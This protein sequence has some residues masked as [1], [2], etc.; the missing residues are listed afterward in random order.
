M[1]VPR[2][3]L[4][5]RWDVTIVNDQ[6]D[7]RCDAVSV[8]VQR[9]RVVLVNDDPLPLALLQSDRQP[10]RECHLPSVLSSRAFEQRGGEGDIDTGRHLQV[11]QVEAA[12]PSVPREELLEPRSSIRVQPLQADGFHHIK[13]EQVL[14]VAAHD[15]VDVAGPDPCRPPLDEFAH[16]I[17]CH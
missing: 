4:R 13:H 14:R 1:A 3:G 2:F 7:P 5:T 9:L 12:R 15:G 10:E 6:P 11:D 8:E 17:R 16:V